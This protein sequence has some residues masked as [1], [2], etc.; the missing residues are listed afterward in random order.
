MRDNNTDNLA[1]LL[2]GWLKTGRR[3]SPNTHDA[4][5]RD[6]GNF[7]E[8]CNKPVHLV[9]ASDVL[10]YQAYLHNQ[11]SEATEYRKLSALRSFFKYLKLAKKITDDPTITIQTPKIEPKFKDKALDIDDVKAI[12]A[13]AEA[14]PADSLLVRL[15]FTT[16]ARISEILALTM[17]DFKAKDDGAFIQLFGKGRHTRGVFIGAKLWADVCTHA[18]EQADDEPLFT[19]NRHEAAA[20][21]AKLAKAAKVTKHVTPHVFRH[22][23]ASFLLADGATLAQVRDQLGHQDIKTTSIYLHG[24]ERTEMIRKLPVQ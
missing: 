10:D 14:M 5:R 12:I 1:S 6:V 4:Y 17:A 18:A 19:I 21:V 7:L 15:L 20:I 24:T 2:D 8:F 16:G 13:A 9:A 3:R 22:S 11:H 23:L